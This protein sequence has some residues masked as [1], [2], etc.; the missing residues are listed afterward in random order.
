MNPILAK[1]ELALTI[2]QQ[3][4]LQASREGIALGQWRDDVLFL[5]REWG[6]PEPDDVLAWVSGGKA[7][8]KAVTDWESTFGVI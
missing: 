8:D 7:S 5:C 4:M 6:L 3:G 2:A 1:T